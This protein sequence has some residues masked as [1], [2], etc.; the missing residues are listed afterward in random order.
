[1]Q[2]SLVD[3]FSN[4]EKSSFNAEENCNKCAEE[5][6]T[7]QPNRKWHE[8][9]HLKGSESTSAER[10]QPFD[11]PRGYTRGYPGTPSGTRSECARGES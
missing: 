3:P 7:T 6:R 4:R 8:L 9:G 1:M 10:W 11:Q 2:V 5:G